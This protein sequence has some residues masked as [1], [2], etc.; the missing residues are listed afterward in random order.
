MAKL[1]NE[2]PVE[3]AE[4][5]TLAFHVDYWDYL[6]WKDKFS[7]PEFGQRQADY[8]K[9]FNLTSNYTPQM[10]VDGMSEFVGSDYPKAISEVGKAKG[11]IKGEVEI[12]LKAELLNPNL[13]IKI[14]DLDTSED[15][16][17]WLAITEDNLETDVKRGEN[18]GKKLSHMSVVRSFEQVGYIATGE[19]KFEIEKIAK[20]D[21][22]WKEEN[23]NFVV[24]VQ[25][26]NS[27][28]V[29]AVGKAKL[30]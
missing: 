11:E 4:I 26:K 10:I 1:Q 13:K 22:V 15:S 23:L 14:S 3:D 9:G 12:I 28:N 25:N 5:I 21:S 16:D 2:Q 19:N 6:G 7:S 24:F 27:K 30:K 17:V 29:V 8:A 20:L 18:S